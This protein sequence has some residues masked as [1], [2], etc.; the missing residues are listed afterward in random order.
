MARGLLLGAASEEAEDNARGDP[1]V[2]LMGVGAE[3]GPV[4]IDIEQTDVDVP[5]W[6][7]V[8]PAADL[9][10]ETVL[11]SI[12][13]AAPADLGVRARSP[14]EGFRKRSQ[15]PSIAEALVGGSR[16]DT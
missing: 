3:R 12:V 5:G 10:R 4:V 9:K 15:A 6:M 7:D 2:V 13:N 11:G 16:A 1:I 14:D 8:Q